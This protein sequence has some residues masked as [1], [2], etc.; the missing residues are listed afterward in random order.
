MER[1]ENGVLASSRRAGY[2]PEVSVVPMSPTQPNGATMARNEKTSKK[3]AKI[4]SKALRDPGSVNKTEIK[5]L[6]GS[7]LTQTPDKKPKA[8]R[9]R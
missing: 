8:K 2:L 7:A 3:I 1:G 4:A 5:K 9:S 6:A